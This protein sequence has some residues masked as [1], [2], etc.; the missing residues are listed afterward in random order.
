MPRASTTLTK[1]VSDDGDYDVLTVM[2]SFKRGCVGR[3]GSLAGCILGRKLDPERAI[4]SSVG[5]NLCESSQEDQENN[6]F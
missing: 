1:G 4:N 6:S 3:L 5:S 2:T